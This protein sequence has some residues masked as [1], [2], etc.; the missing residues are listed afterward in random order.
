MEAKLKDA[1]DTMEETIKTRQG[2]VVKEL[3]EQFKEESKKAEKLRKELER[4][5]RALQI[6]VQEFDLKINNLIKAQESESY[7]SKAL[8][9]TDNGPLLD[10]MREQVLNVP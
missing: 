8:V 3:R 7:T 6:N 4:E 2:A 9:H 1:I 10:S 5:N